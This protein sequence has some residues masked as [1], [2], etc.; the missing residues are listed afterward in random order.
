[1]LTSQTLV[2]AIVPQVLLPAKGRDRAPAQMMLALPVYFL[3]A[4][5][6]ADTDLAAAVVVEVVS[7]ISQDRPPHRHAPADP[8]SAVRYAQD[9][10]AFQ[11]RLVNRRTSV[12]HSIPTTPAEMAEEVAAAARLVYLR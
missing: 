3:P 5:T 6:L 1:L 7:P 8:A 11:T 10:I 9:T 12:I 2:L 4:A